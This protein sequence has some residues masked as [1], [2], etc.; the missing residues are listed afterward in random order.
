M[1]YLLIVLGLFSG[2]QSTPECT[3]DLAVVIHGFQGQQG[4]A[5]AALFA[6]PAGFPLG[7][8]KALRKDLVP[9]VDGMAT[10]KFSGLPAATYALAV[11]HDENGNEKLDRNWVGRPTEGYG[12]SNDAPARRFGAPDYEDARFEAGCG[13]H[14]LE[15]QLRY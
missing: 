4:Q 10:V 11:M 3:A 7:V 8:E 6:T 13:T 15:V 5:G 1:T 2:V 14:K 9:I 12:V